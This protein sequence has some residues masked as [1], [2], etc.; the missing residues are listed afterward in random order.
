MAS[1]APCNRSL[2]QHIQRVN[3][4]VGIWKRA[5][6]QHPDIPKAHHGHGWKMEESIL[7]PIWYEGC[8]LPQELADIALDDSESSVDPDADEVEPDSLEY[9]SDESDNESDNL[10]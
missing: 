6:I 3:H 8:M 7:Q 1:F 4:Q 5:T 10:F 9:F 2:I